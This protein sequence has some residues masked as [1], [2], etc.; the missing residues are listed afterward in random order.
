VRVRECE[1]VKVYALRI[2][3]IGILIQGSD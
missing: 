2:F 3:E 1:V